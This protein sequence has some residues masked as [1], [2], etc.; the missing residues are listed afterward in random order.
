MKRKRNSYGF[1]K[2]NES[3]VSLTLG[4][5]QLNGKR[6]D[7]SHSH[8]LIWCKLKIRGE[9]V[10]KILSAELPD[11]DGDPELYETINTLLIHGPCIV[12]NPDSSWMQ[13]KN[14][15]KRYPKALRVIGE[16]ITLGNQWVLPYNKLLCKILKKGHIIVEYSSS[17]KIHHKICQQ[18]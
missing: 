6:E 18:G 9:D 4:L 12:I 7:S 11:K 15:I 8:T 13:D 2:K 10:D 3:L 17:V 16:E 5:Q 1:L 14:C